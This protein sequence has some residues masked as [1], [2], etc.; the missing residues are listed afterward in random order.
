M[1][2]PK[3]PQISTTSERATRT[4]AHLILKKKAGHER[5]KN[6]LNG[7]H[8]RLHTDSNHLQQQHNLEEKERRKINQTEQ[9]RTE[10][11]NQK[12]CS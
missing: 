10:I 6:V 11:Q 9:I 7:S 3:Q 12:L 4:E 2:S 5:H 8:N 1:K